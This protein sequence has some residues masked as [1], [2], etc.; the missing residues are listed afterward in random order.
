MRRHLWILRTGAFP[1]YHL[2]GP[3]HVPG[4]HEYLR[5]LDRQRTALALIVRKPAD[6]PQLA[7]LGTDAAGND[8]PILLLFASTIPATTP[9][10]WCGLPFV[11]GW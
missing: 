2:L 10:A 11:V 5:G 1:G 4:F 9:P 3:E 7:E 8:D 6:L